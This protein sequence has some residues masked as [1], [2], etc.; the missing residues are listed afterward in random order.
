MDVYWND[1]YVNY[2]RGF[3]LDTTPAESFRDCIKTQYQVNMEN[4][5]I[6]TPAGNEVDYYKTIEQNGIRDGMV[7]KAVITG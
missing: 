7:L 3:G 1:S 5:H 4:V 6:Y 2:V